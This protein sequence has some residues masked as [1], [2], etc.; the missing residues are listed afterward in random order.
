MRL[1]TNLENLGA[2]ILFD[3][4]DANHNVVQ[5]TKEQYDS[6]NVKLVNNDGEQGP[7][8]IVA[9]PQPTGKG[10]DLYYACGRYPDATTGIGLHCKKVDGGN[11][12]VAIS[13]KKDC[14]G[15]N[16]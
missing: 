11:M 9:P 2:E 6:C 12:R 3:Y 1:K 15:S 13:V 7:K 4:K 8:T 14:N 5:L 10:H 16:N